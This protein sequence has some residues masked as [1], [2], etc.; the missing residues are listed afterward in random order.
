MIDRDVH[1]SDHAIQRFRRRCS[2]GGPWPELDQGDMKRWLGRMVRENAHA[3]RYFQSPGQRARALVVPLVDEGALL[4]VAICGAAR[5]RPAR[6]AVK[7]VYRVS[8][9]GWAGSTESFL[10]EWWREWAES[11]AL[12]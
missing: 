5:F 8:Q 2:E 11:L 3:A 1:V 7:T 10:P 4:A 9:D 6:V 12:R